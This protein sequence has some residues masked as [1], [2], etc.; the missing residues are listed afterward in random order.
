MGDQPGTSEG[1]GPA[2]VK[3]VDE[4]RAQRYEARVGETVVGYTEYR[5]VERDRMIL[6][7]TEVDPAF[8][9]KGYGSRLAAGVLDD[10]RTRG[11]RLTVKCPFM[12]AYLK[13]HREYEDLVPHPAG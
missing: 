10:I 13:R 5:M 8:E 3:I 7:H 1:S 4:T 11:L 9:G 2:G 6:V 12:A